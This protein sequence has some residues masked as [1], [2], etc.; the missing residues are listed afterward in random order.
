M[1]QPAPRRVLQFP[2]A[3]AAHENQRLSSKGVVKKLSTRRKCTSRGALSR[4]HLSM[5][6]LLDLIVYN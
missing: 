5:N 6:I 1:T 3:T 2:I 4:K